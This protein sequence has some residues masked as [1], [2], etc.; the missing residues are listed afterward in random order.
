MKYKPNT[1]TNSLLVFH[2]AQC[3]KIFDMQISLLI[4]INKYEMQEPKT[5][6]QY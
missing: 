3:K 6:N 2:F 1:K 5:Q 4:M